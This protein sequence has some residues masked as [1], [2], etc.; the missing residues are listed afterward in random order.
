MRTV[1]PVGIVGYGAYVPMYRIKDVEIARVW[2]SEGRGLPVQEKA[3]PG[4]DEDTLTIAAEAARNAID[5]ALVSP[6]DLGAI[7]V[8]TESKPYAVKPTGTILSQALGTSRGT[9]AADME[10]ACKA[11]TE[12]FQACMGLVG[13]GMTKYAMGIGVDV[14]Q[15]R[16]ADELE[17]TAGAGGS[18]FIFGRNTADCVARVE[19]S[20]SFVTDTPDFWRRQGQV[21]PRHAGRFT[22]DPAYFKHVTE[23]S[24][25]LMS[26]LGLG[27]TDFDYAV[28]HQPNTKFPLRAASLLGIPA[29]R[30]NP[31]LLSAVIGN[32]YAGSSPLGLA[33]TL[34]VAKP[35]A[36]ILMTS[37]G[38]GAGSDAFSI[39]V[40]EA[41]VR[42][43]NL[44]PLVEDY[45]NRRVEVDYVTY[46]RNK[47]KILR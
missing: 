8:G 46:A 35:G 22:G 10:F 34:D 11:G 15:A 3:L 44:A 40:Q 12:A 26:E 27:P 28:F 4:V 18:A 13:S 38:S 29:E 32:A 21:Y 19:G 17:F 20:Y 5:R 14:A 30:L 31:G 7:Y 33:S 6:G 37:F 36:R 23:A 43:R 39:V 9:L 41:V 45:L 47:G 42:K 25:R 24:K 1:E 2:G 16:P